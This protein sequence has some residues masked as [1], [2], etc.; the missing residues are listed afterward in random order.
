[1][2]FDLVKVGDSIKVEVETSKVS[3]PQEYSIENALKAAYLVLRQTVDRNKRPA[4]EV[5]TQ[6]S[7]HSALL[8]MVVQGLN[9]IKDQCYFP[10]FGNKLV[11]MRGY[12]GS[13]MM[14]KRVDRRVLDI[15]A[16]VIYDGDKFG[17]VIL[18]GKKTIKIHEQELSNIKK[19]RIIGAYAMA[20]GEEEKIISTDIMT[21]A[22]IETSWRQSNMRLFDDSG[23]LL[24]NTTH[25]KFKAEMCKKTV[26][27]RLC[28]P[29]INQS[30]DGILLRSF[31]N[32]DEENALEN[33]VEAEIA[34]NANA[35][36]IDFNS[37]ESA[38][39][40]E[41]MATKSM[42]QVIC[43]LSAKLNHDKNRMLKEVGS[44]VGRDIK[45][46]SQLTEIEADN[47]I[48]VLDNELISDTDNPT[49]WAD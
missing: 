3:L 43:D 14:A 16:E 31:R 26:I 22:E 12:M 48:K 20:I 44:F 6:E 23:H 42:A 33:Q 11:C 46:L 30:T 9:P 15:R 10:V 28:K 35:K 39:E 40:T 27:H 4:L 19:D 8:D 25:F 41:P 21:I 7:I 32:S 13:A 29:L 36:M 5:C 17:F 34:E 18:N 49:D 47:Y 2:N 37:D 45:K 24:E 38:I 1:M